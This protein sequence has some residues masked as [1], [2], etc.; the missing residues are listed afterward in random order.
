MGRPLVL[1]KYMIW[2][3]LGGQKFAGICILQLYNYGLEMDY[4]LLEA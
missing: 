2:T 1:T 4:K 3:G